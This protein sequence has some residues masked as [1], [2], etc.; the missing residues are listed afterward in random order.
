MI[1][2]VCLDD[3][4]VDVKKLSNVIKKE[5]K[6]VASVKSQEKLFE[7]E[8]YMTKEDFWEEADKRIIS[9]CKKYGVL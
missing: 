2:T 5:K 7:S 4:Y 1:H 8:G 6:E 9:V 3:E